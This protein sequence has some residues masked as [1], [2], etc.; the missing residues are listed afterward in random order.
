M[1]VI[2]NI[3]IAF[4][5]FWLSLWV[6]ALLGWPFSKL[7]DGIV[8]GDSM[9]SAIAMGVMSSLNR[10]V[11]AILAGILVTLTL[12]HRKSEFWALIVGVLYVIDAPV[13]H[14]WSSPA[15]GWDRLWQGIDLVFPAVA[16]IVTA[17]I[18]A[19]LRSGRHDPERP[20]PKKQ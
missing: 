4:G 13:R 7:G 6:A 20:A 2:R 15:S 11:A 10:T 5:V 3:L 14:H 1:S 17:F 9:L 18:T 16:C 8:Y 19:S 12:D